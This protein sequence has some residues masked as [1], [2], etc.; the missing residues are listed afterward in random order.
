[1][2]TVLWGEPQALKEV[3]NSSLR[4]VNNIQEYVTNNPVEIVCV[5][6]CKSSLVHNSRG[7]GSLNTV[8]YWTHHCKPKPS[9]KTAT[10]TY[11]EWYIPW[12][13]NQG[14]WAE[15]HI[16]VYIEEKEENSYRNWDTTIRDWELS[17]LAEVIGF[18]VAL[19]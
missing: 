3:G 12:R 5:G 19:G 4:V 9:C 1:M 18:H 10:E 13:N 11:L 7:L 15:F 16:W 8:T 14:N 2:V 6:L 17:G